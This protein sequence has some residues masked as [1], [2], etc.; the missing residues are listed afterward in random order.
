MSRNESNITGLLFSFVAGAL[1]G[2]AVALWFAPMT[3]KK[4]QKKVGNVADK[5]V[6][7][8]DDLQDR[9]RRLAKV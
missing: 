2:A 4:L 8:Y 3:G 5:V 7:T 9:V 1:T 6:D